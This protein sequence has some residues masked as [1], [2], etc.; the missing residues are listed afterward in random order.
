MR[1]GLRQSSGAFGWLA[2]L[3]KAPEDW[4][5]PKPDGGL[6]RRF[7]ESL[8]GL[9]L[10]P[11]DVQRAPGS[12]PSLNPVLALKFAY[13]VSFAL[14]APLA[15]GPLTLFLDLFDNLNAAASLAYV[16]GVRIESEA[17][18]AVKLHSAAALGGC[19]RRIVRG[20]AGRGVG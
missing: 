14:P 18:A 6:R 17:P 9:P 7:M 10:E 20:G 12:F 15:G 11:A 2:S 16:Q 8:L 4:R 19:D 1:L 13:S 5:T 3:A